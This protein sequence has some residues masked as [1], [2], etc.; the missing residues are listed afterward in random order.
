[1]ENMTKNNLLNRQLETDLTRDSELFLWL[2]KVQENCVVEISNRNL[3]I[4]A[5][6]K[7]KESDTPLPLILTLCPAVFNLNFPTQKGQ[8]RELVP[9]ETD[10][11]RVKSLF[12]EISGFQ[13]LLKNLTGLDTDLFLVFG[14]LLEKGSER[15]LTNSENINTIS[16]TS[17]KSMREIIVNIDRESNG[18]FQRMGIKVPKVRLQS[19]ISQQGGKIN[20][21]REQM[22]NQFETSILD[23]NSNFFTLWSK[24]LK[25]ARDDAKFTETS[26]QGQK[27][28]EAIWNRMR[29]LIAELT[30]DGI[31]LPEIMKHLNKGIMTE[32][33][34]LASSTRQ[35]TLKMESDCFNLVKQRVLI[36]AFRNIGKWLEPAESSPWIDILRNV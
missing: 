18:L 3:V 35:A 19:G 29:F 2:N 28:A 7:S 32:P 5:I 33:V 25:L 24:H 23:P 9:I 8:T 27:S 30:A 11:L 1:M 21:N 26:W 10:N 34:F 15:M 36:P 17:V 20:L 16:Q 13:I 31:F 12:E 6:S 14:D 4:D 22:I